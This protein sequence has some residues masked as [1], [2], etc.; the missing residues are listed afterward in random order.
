MHIEIPDPWLWLCQPAV[1]EKF[2]QRHFTFR[3]SNAL[4]LARVGY[5]AE[6]PEKNPPKKYPARV[7]KRYRFQISFLEGLLSGHHIFAALFFAIA[8]FDFGL[9]FT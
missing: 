2:N 3:F 8:D 1:G 5:F 7:T 9:L 4:R 6:F